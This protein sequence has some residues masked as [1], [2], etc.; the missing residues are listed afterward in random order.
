VSA[1]TKKRV[2]KAKK[3]AQ[4][5]EDFKINRL[6]P[7]DFCKKEGIHTSKF[8]YWRARY[9]EKGIEGLIDQR[10]GMAYKMTKE[11]K[12]FI[13]EEK[14]KDRLKSGIDLSKMIENK[15]GKK[16]SEIHIQQFLKELRLNDPTGRKAG[17]HKIKKRVIKNVVAGVGFLFGAVNVINGEE[18]ISEVIREMKDSHSDGQRIHSHKVSTLLRYI[19]TLFFLPAFGMERPIELDSYDGK[20]LGA[21]TSP[22]GRHA[23]YRTTDRFLRDLTALKVG[24]DLSLALA[25]H[26]YKTFYGTE[27]LPVY[28]DGHFKAVWTLKNIPK[29]MHGM[30]DRVMPGLKEIF[31]NGNNGHPL[32]HKTCPGD[33]HLTKELLS[34]VEDFEKAIGLEIVNAVIFDGEGCSIDV[35]RAFD[36]LNEERENKFYPVTVLD[37]NQYRLDDFKIP[38]GKGT[39]VV[40]DSDFE[41]LKRNKRGKVV[42]RVALVEF[43]YLSNAN[44]RQKGE[45]KEEYTMRCALVK[46]ENGKHTVIVTTAPNVEIGSGS[47]LADLYYN[48]WPCQEAK[49]KEMAK[50]CNLKVNHGFKKKEVFNR[51]AAKKLETAE[52]SLNYHIRRLNNL[53][54][55]LEGVKRQMG[56]SVTQREKAREK[57]MRQIEAIR[58]KIS[59]QKGDM[60]NLKMQR[61][62]KEG[63]LVEV[64]AKYQN[65][66]GS[67]GEKERV[68]DKTKNQILKLMEKK[69]VEVDKWKK[70]L[71]KTPFYELDTET[72]RVMTN[73][74]IL[75]ENSLLFAKE[76]FFDGNVGMEMMNRQFINHYGD[77]EIL[78]GGKR[79][80][81][82]LNKFDGKGLREKAMNACRIFN[83]KNI[84]TVDGISLEIVVKK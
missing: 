65:K 58:D 40:E 23:R 38:D 18:A 61:G 44:R 72:D 24:N 83:V 25:G 1:V 16:I 17:K 55:N 28:I 13:V 64:E 67:L 36:R 82:K 14:L 35:F 20:T 7:T 76:V 22:D 10:E 63:E 33:R 2:E 3:L 52:K 9:T 5:F 45:D 79:F 54:E 15:F 42:S 26:Y 51:M 31:L 74:K 78:D 49:F 43:N 71:E 6:S 84:K 70:E 56:K 57:L 81:F 69:R 41:V 19:R 21:I 62:R 50:Y 73:F 59:D 32:L 53:E 11:V 4:M 77:L 68:L 39:R 75:Y 80:R 47:K 66:R 46:K 30:M 29:G 8:Y 37:S 60:D 12:D 34:I 27:K 48:R